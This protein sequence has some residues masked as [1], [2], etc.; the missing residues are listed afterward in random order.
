MC[1][2]CDKH[3]G[4]ET[5]AQVRYEEIHTLGGVSTS[6]YIM[7]ARTQEEQARLKVSLDSIHDELKKL[8]K[9][10]MRKIQDSL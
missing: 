5:I 1:K 10:D 6:A 7:G 3:N 4:L 2:D 9:Q 8:I